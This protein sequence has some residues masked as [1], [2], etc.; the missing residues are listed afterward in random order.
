PPRR[1]RPSA[2]CPYTTLF[3]SEPVG[4][5]LVGEQLGRRADRARLLGEDPLQVAVDGLQVGAKGRVVQRGSASASRYSV[6]SGW[7]RSAVRSEELTSELQS[8][9][10]LVCRR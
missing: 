9:E 8:R 10:N 2:R 1:C 4:G 6:T 7:V 3:R 5:D